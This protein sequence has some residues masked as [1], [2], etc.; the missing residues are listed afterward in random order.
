MSLTKLHLF[1]KDTDA[2]ATEQGFYFQKLIT[3]RT[4]LQNRLE[5]NDT[6][7]YCD[8]EEDI[9]ERSVDAGTSTFRQV[10]LYSEN[11]SFSKEE[12]VKSIAHFF[13]LYCKGDYILDDVIFIFETNSRPAR[14]YKTE[15]PKL[16]KEWWQNQ[17]ELSPQMLERCRIKVKSII[18][19]YIT[20]VMSAKL[21][22]EMD[23]AMKEAKE[24][25][26]RLPDDVWNDFVRSIRWKFDAVPQE[27]AI[28]QL[29]KE[30]EELVI[31]LP[32]S[33]NPDQATTYISVLLSEIAARTA[34]KDTQ[35]KILTNLSLD[36]L[37]LNM[38]SEKDRWYAAFYEK[39]KEEEMINDFRVGEFYEIIA[40]TRHCRWELIETDHDDLWCSLLKQYIELEETLTSCRRKAIYEY[41]FILLSPDS[42]TFTIK[43]TIEGTEHLIRYY[44]ENLDDRNSFSDI[45]DDIILLEIAAKYSESFPELITFQEIENWRNSIHTTI[46]NKISNHNNVDELCLALQLMGNFH[47]HNDPSISILDKT[48]QS[49][50]F[51]SKIPEIL[52]QAR[53]YSITTLNNQTSAILDLLIRLDAEIAAIQVLEEYLDSIE[54][55][56]MKTGQNLE[57]AKTLVQRS[58]SYL[59]RPSVANYLKALGCLHKAKDYC[60]NDDARPQLIMV[61]NNIAKVY[62]ALGMNIASKYYGLTALWGSVHF[63]DHTILKLIGDSYASVFHADYQQG[64]WVSALD[65]FQNYIHARIEFNADDLDLERDHVLANVLVELGFILSTAAIIHPELQAFIQHQKQKIGWIY[66][67]FLQEIGQ[68]TEAKFRDQN[69]LKELLKRKLTMIPFSDIGPSRKIE[70]DTHGIKWNIVFS[71]EV[72]MNAIAEEFTALFQIILCEI[73]LM[74]VDLHLLKMPVTIHLSQDNEY[75]HDFKQRISHDEA[76][77]DLAIPALE[78]TDQLKIQYHY[79]FLTSRIR[80]LL[81]NLSLL[82][83]KEFYEAFDSLYR[84]QNLGHKGLIINTYQKVYFNHLTEEQFSESHRSAFNPVSFDDFNS[85]GSRLDID[86]KGVSAKYD[87]AASLEKIAG[88]YKRNYKSLSVSLEIWK[89]D[90]NF[91]ILINSLRSTGFLDWQILSA[92]RNFVIAKKVNIL[93]QRN[94]PSTDQ[95][96]AA[97]AAKLS[98]EMRRQLED[99]NYIPIPLEWLT[100]PE[101]SFYMN[102]VPVD[103]LDS[104]GLQNG[105]K[106]PNFS[107]VHSYLSIRFGFSSDDNSE[108]SPLK[109]L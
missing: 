109:D 76:V 38:G 73:G 44:F 29:V 55:L 27:N 86:F 36:I 83:S 43:N 94:P 58:S 74:S 40:A 35:K 63:G 107:A 25:Y 33:L 71:N 23:K 21:S 46:D 97:L 37:L 24:I 101:F 81:S 84:K 60:N 49:V 57:T 53:T 45:E 90:P 3:L 99:Q 87:Q 78:V 59:S 56:A 92:L 4:W 15:D 47:F 69:K 102:K 42:K 67:E 64:S 91:K 66:T 85:E 77:W 95:E 72:K 93:L 41:I 103:V 65:D 5:Q 18:D 52:P 100:S 16:L 70:F 8:Y 82:P 11:F 68:H 20:S 1:T 17:D 61:L 22:P 10:K 98:T 105:M 54:V 7:I 34:E 88:R 96:A 48:I 51:Y 2:T 6:D 75:T 79:V 30:L 106:Y 108:E 32:F 50:E 26:D 104:Y 28:T 31:Q 9:F 13:M 14:Q 39:W 89:R 12:I 19:E 80:T 62:W